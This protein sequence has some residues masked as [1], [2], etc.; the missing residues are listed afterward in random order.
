M[1]Q[2]VHK[3]YLFITAPLI[4]LIIGFWTVLQ[5]LFI[6]WNNGD[7]SYCYFIIPLFA[8]LCWE[9][10]K[11]FHFREFSWTPWGVLS[12]VFSVALI[13]LGEMGS[14]ETF[15]Y[16]GLWGCITSIVFLLYGKRI[17]SLVFPIIILLFIVPLPPFING[18]L[19]FYL[20]M[21]A[22]K[23]SVDLLSFA[24]ASVIQEG[25][26]IDFGI[27]Q[28]EVADACSGLRYF[29]PMILMGILMAHYFTRGLWRKLIVFLLIIPLSIF[30]NVI[31]IF[32]AGL[33]VVYGRPEL[34]ANMFH[35]FTGW[36]AFIVAGLI[37]YAVTLTLKHAG[38]NPSLKNLVDIQSPGTIPP[39]MRFSLSYI[40]LCAVFLLGGLGL[41]QISSLSSIPHRSPFSGFPMRIDQ[42]NGTRTYFSEEIMQSLWAD[43]YVSATYQKPG[44]LNVIRLLIPFYAYQGTRHTV[45]APQSC[46]LGGGWSIMSSNDFPITLP[47]KMITAKLMMLEKD[48]QKLIGTYFFLERGRIITSPWMNKLYLIKDSILKRRTDG[49]LVRVELLIGENTSLENAKEELQSFIIH[50]WPLL[51]AYVPD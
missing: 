44:S 32:F 18:T 22:S 36:L 3:K 41:M 51:P 19:T 30:I 14:L 1:N 37:L 7:D 28:L 39:G 33:C 46:L 23:L 9:K 13:I 48:N 8:Y 10:R 25:N 38:T 12:G 50:L 24:G 17:R 40:T 47:G 5:K 4:C 35:D 29:M 49:A 31:R 27:R 26:I 43:D 16:I 42:W 34:V 20:K 6:R 45:H 15:T 21:V 2:H 11:Y